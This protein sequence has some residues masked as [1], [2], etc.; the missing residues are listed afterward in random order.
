[1][2]IGQFKLVAGS[3]ACIAGGFFG[4]GCGTYLSA[5]THEDYGFI[6]VVGVDEMLEAFQL[7]GV[8][9]GIFPLTFVGI[10]Q[11]LHL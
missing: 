2:S 6:F 3:K 9:D 8:I 5:I 10:D 1:M 11:V 4:V 7:L